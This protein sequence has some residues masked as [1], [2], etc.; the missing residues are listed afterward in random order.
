MH[1]YLK[2]LYLNYQ[3]KLTAAN[4][5]KQQLLFLK[6]C[7]RNK[8]LPKTM[9]PHQ[10]KHTQCEPF[11]SIFHQILK[12]RIN[13]VAN[14]IKITFR[15]CNLT[16]KLFQSQWFSYY[17]EEIIQFSNQI[18]KAHQHKEQIVYSKAASLKFKFNKIYENSLWTKNS[19]PCN[20]VNLSTYTLRRDEKI[21]LGYG[22]SLAINNKD[23]WP[24]ALQEFE[25]WKKNDK[26]KSCNNDILKGMIFGAIL[27]TENIDNFPE[28]F[29]RA[30]VNLR[31]NNSI[32]ISRA[33]KGNKIV[34][35]N[36]H[37][38][39]SKC[40][41]L[42]NDTNTYQT[43]TNN[44]HKQS[45]QTFNN[46]LQQILKEYPTIHKNNKAYM[47]QIPQFY[48][49]P[50]THKPNVPLR[51]IIANTN[52]HTYKLAQWLS[53]QLKP[54]LS[55]ISSSHLKNTEEF[56]KKTASLNP[57]TH[58]FISYDVISLFTS[59]PVAHLLQ[60]LTTY[61]NE[62]NINLQ[63]PFPILK[64]LILLTLEHN[65]FQYN[66]TF[67]KQKEG[68]SMGSPLSP[69]LSNIYMEL[70]EHYYIH[71]HPLLRNTTWLRYVDDIFAAIPISTNPTAILNHINNIHPNIQFT[72]E[73]PAPTQNSLP[74]LD[75]LILWDHTTKPSYTI[76]RKP[77]SS[78]NY[79]HWYSAHTKNIK[80]ATLSAL[81]LRAFKICSPAY[82]K[83][84]NDFL[85]NTFKKLQYS[86]YIINKSYK[87][88]KTK[89]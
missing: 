13:Q 75:T 83:T 24:H 89:F 40:I 49:V 47:T 82:L 81:Y 5:K 87:K 15:K 12:E 31:K 53:V 55:K 6:C 19:N 51:P 54:L 43:L 56:I 73:I 85:K 27:Q 8:V 38:Y 1:R 32:I 3:S 80:I 4:V 60:L 65:Y 48:G 17:P 37:Q 9:V 57:K 84:E 42:L 2:R 25:K 72:M 45:Q 78:P 63:Y 70:I 86:I 62:N 21:L 88:A 7:L 59:V 22:L 69:M 29:H 23:P 41:N 76:Y 39:N 33:D 50:K 14:E 10:L 11:P 30:L 46:S 77:T 36:T 34:I 74:F 68:L 79:I 64:Q 44:P 35:M 67:Y 16:L 26:G 52:P 20:I 58:K 66:Q 71:P 28:K 61:I 18:Q